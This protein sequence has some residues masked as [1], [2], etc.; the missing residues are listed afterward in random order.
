MTIWRHSATA[1]LDNDTCETHA[2]ISRFLS[3]DCR[4]RETGRRKSKLDVLKERV[5][6]L[7]A[8]FD[9]LGVSVPL[10]ETDTS[11]AYRTRGA[12]NAQNKKTE[13]RRGELQLLTGRVT[14]LEECLR[15]QGYELP[16]H[17]HEQTGD[18]S[19]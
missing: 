12:G 14:Q 3:D 10:V 19:E 4:G 17:G 18:G 5:A 7:L 9:R 13:R 2:P 1:S 11:K 6:E 8:E 15:A 16:S